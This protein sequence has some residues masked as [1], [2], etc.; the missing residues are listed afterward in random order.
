MPSY[1]SKLEK[2]KGKMYQKRKYESTG[3]SSDT[4]TG[5]YMSMLMSAAWQELT[6]KQQ[7]LYIYCKS[8]RYAEKK[9]P[10]KDNEASFT[11]NQS[12]WHGLYGLYTLNNKS[13]FYK[14]MSALIEKGFIRCL[15]CGSVTR[16]KS[17]YEF[18][19]K[20]QKYGTPEFKILPSEMTSS[21]LKKMKN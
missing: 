19:D 3:I 6:G 18:S 11:M 16:T 10:I 17:I 20:W 21:M 13:S 9:K 8:Q 4:F 14:D 15:E 12:K 2:L 1:R 7:V 5:I